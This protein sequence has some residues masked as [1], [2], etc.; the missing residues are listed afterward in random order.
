MAA[1]ALPEWRAAQRNLAVKL[2]NGEA[3]PAANE[4]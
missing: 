2:F 1:A 3:L 4:K